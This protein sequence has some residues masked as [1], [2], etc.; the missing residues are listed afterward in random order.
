MNHNKVNEAGYNEATK[1][2]PSE[3]NPPK[4]DFEKGIEIDPTNVDY[5]VHYE[6]LKQ[7]SEVPVIT[8]DAPF[9]SYSAVPKDLC[10][11]KVCVN[12]TS[13]LEDMK[14]YINY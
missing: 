1:F 10:R 11:I 2:G 13:Q 3:N 5:K 9:K 8:W 7:K 12:S 14:I 4:L 6:L